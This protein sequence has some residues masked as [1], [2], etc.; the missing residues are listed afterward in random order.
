MYY[1]TEVYSSLTNIFKFSNGEEVSTNMNKVS[2]QSQESHIFSELEF[3][4]I[5]FLFICQIVVL[6]FVP[7]LKGSI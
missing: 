7:V 4:L 6:S 1:F 3:C 2:P 5:S